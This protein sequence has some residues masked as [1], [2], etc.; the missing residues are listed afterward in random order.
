M[1]EEKLKQMG[2]IIPEAVKPL[3][4]YPAMQLEIQ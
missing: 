4:A 2:I 3:A 1:F